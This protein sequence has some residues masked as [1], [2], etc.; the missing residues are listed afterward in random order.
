[1]RVVDRHK[2]SEQS[3]DGLE[4]DHLER[5]AFLFYGL[6]QLVIVELE[7]FADGFIALV[8]ASEAL[9]VVCSELVVFE[10][11]C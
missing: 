11:K 4:G 10:Q 6:F 3:H 9:D 2:I 5:H 1:M 7:P 8:E